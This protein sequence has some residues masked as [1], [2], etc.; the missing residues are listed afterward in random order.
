MFTQMTDADRC[1]GLS[2]PGPD[3]LYVWLEPWADEIEVPARSAITLD[4]SGGPD[5]CPLGQV[6]WSTDHLV[7]WATAQRIAVSVDGVL[8]RSVSASVPA[9]DGLTKGMLGIMFADRPAAR[10][11]GAPLYLIGRPSWW[12]LIKRR[13]GL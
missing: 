12:Q 1:W 11:G 6:E 3:T 13:V 5:D 10:L 8:Q 7:V 9:P 2:N 4:P